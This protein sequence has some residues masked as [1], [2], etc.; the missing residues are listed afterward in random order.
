MVTAKKLDL[1]KLHKT[2]YRAPQ[3]PQLIAITPASY[4]MITGKGEPGG[5]AFYHEIYL[6]DPRRGPE[7]RLRA[8]L[9]H[10]VN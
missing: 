10:P 5:D 3:T 6:S 1:Y 9:R 8:I 7:H 4:L 2:D